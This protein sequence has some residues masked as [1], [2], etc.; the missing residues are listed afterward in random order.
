MRI[1][2]AHPA[3]GRAR[4]MT[5]RGGFAVPLAMFAIVIIS[6]LLSG[7][8]FVAIRQFQIGHAGLQAS[9]GLYVAEAGLSAVRV[10]PRTVYVDASR[11][12]WVEGFIRRTF[13]AMIEGV[14]EPSV[15]AGLLSAEAFDAGIRDLHR[16]AEPDGTFSYTF[17]EGVGRR[18]ASA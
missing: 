8:V 12:E 15:E 5:G 17:F 11:P 2:S 9:A 16:T 1:P 3:I 6:A 7:G 4:T 18:P 14:R 13:T 10:S